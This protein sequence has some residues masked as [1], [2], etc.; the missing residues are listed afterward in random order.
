M[1]RFELAT[2]QYPGAVQPRGFEL[3]E[4]F[5]LDPFPTWRYRCGAAAITKTVC[6]LD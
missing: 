2:V 4:E 5:R 1:K 6:L 3:L